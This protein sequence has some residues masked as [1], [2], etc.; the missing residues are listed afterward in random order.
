MKKMDIEQGVLWPTAEQVEKARAE[1]R[2]RLQDEDLERAL[3]RHAVNG[4]MKLLKVDRENFLKLW[5]EPLM[6][7]GASL[8]IALSCIAQSQFQPN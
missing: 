8:D 2:K 3:R 7:A 1:L 5:I 6:T 4:L